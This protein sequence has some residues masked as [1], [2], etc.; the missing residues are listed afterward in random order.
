MSPGLDLGN[1]TQTYI[2][3]LSKTH[4]RFLDER[5]FVERI[6]LDR[7]DTR[8]NRILDLPNFLARSVEDY[9]LASESGLQRFPKLA[10]RVYLDVDTGILHR[11]ENAERRHSLCGVTDLERAADDR[12]T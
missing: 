6:D 8:L 12:S 7:I 9:L 3:G 4:G 5:E 2:R 11:P 10:A 1:Q